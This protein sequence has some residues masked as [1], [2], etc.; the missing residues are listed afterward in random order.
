MAGRV[1]LALAG[2]AAAA[3][4]AAALVWMSCSA[5]EV[6]LWLHE[7]ADTP[8]YSLP[9]DSLMLPGESPHLRPAPVWDRPRFEEGRAARLEMVARQIEWRDVKDPATVDAMREV[10]RHMFVPSDVRRQAHADRPLPIG[11][12][13]TISQPYI[14][15]YMTELLDLDPGERVLEVGTGSGYQAAVLSELTPHVFTMEII[16]PLAAQ[17][18]ER[19]REL[20]YMTVQV[21]QGDGYYG[22]EEHAPYDAIIVTAAAGHVPPP[23]LAQLDVGGRMVI[24]VGGV[25]EVQ[26]LVLVTRDEEGALRSRRVLPV[27][28]VPMTGRVQEEDRPG[29]A[30]G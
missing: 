12:G 27:R 7:P 25:F 19:L 5:G 23:L 11:Y 28:F 18:A 13:Q 15:A 17:A 26:H 14:V 4:S 10:P 20:G 22:W 2:T 8:F 21:R 1:G 29:D 30:G 3:A 16:E 9:E 24:P 6:P